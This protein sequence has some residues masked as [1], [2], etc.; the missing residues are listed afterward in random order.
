[1]RWTFSMIATSNTARSSISLTMIGMSVSRACWA[2][3]QRRSPAM[4]CQ[5]P[6]WPGWERTRTGCSTP[7]SRIEAASSSSSS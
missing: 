4:I 3:R 1:V 7:L 6:S 5:T 2:A